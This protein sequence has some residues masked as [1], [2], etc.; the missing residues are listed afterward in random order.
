MVVFVVMVY[1]CVAMVTL[2]THLEYSRIRSMCSRPRFWGVCECVCAFG[3][4]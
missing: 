1:Q 2:M 3:D 4:V